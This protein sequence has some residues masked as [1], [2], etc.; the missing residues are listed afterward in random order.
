[1][2]QGK[3]SALRQ[4]LAQGFAPIFAPTAI[5]ALDKHGPHPMPYK[6]VEDCEERGGM[7]RRSGAPAMQNR[8][9]DHRI[10]RQDETTSADGDDRTNFDEVPAIYRSRHNHGRS[11]DAAL[12]GKQ[13]YSEL[14][15]C[16]LFLGFPELL[17]VLEQQPTKV[18]ILLFCSA[19]QR[20]L[21][22]GMSKGM[23]R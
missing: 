3:K 6:R 5:G 10:N 19:S 23:G 15:E 4:F 1:M 20:V 11:P 2:A 7:A 9:R 13:N 14:L 21:F 12:F 22:F 8:G 18:F 16:C 17:L